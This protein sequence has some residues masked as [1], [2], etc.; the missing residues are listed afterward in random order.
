MA[1]IGTDLVEV[2]AGDDWRF[3]VEN[4]TFRAGRTTASFSSFTA[5]IREDPDYASRR[6][7]QANVDP[8]AEGW[9]VVGSPASGTADGADA[10]Y[11][12]FPDTDTDELEGSERRYVID[13]VGV[14]TTGSAKA[15]IFRTNWLKVNPRTTA[16]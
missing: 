13:A 16:Y 10:V 8:I 15:T 3:R 12:D 9:A 7:V 1:V 11:F 2:S 4:I 6:G 5:T 14:V